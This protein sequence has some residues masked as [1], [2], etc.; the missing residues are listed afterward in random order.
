MHTPDRHKLRK[1]Q[2][3][4]A[5]QKDP[6]R[7]LL[8]C[9]TASA[10]LCWSFCLRNRLLAHGLEFCLV[11]ILSPQPSR[12]R[13]GPGPCQR[14][15]GA[16]QASHWRFALRRPVGLRPQK[17]PRPDPSLHKGAY[18]TSG[19]FRP[20]RQCSSS[21]HDPRKLPRR[22]SHCAIKIQV[23]KQKS[24]THAKRVALRNKRAEDITSCQGNIWSQSN[25]EL[26]RQPCM[27]PSCCA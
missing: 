26:R 21:G 14:Q 6:S 22:R 9:K 8:Q 11:L 20:R 27:P 25:Q 23:S 10:R 7:H 24:E 17:M 13:P 16:P 1:K 4:T 18:H 19:S 3:S 15:R 12:L 5:N 2:G